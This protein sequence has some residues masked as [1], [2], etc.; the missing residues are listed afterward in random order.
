MQRRVIGGLLIGLAAL[1][2]G[3]ASL[4]SPEVMKAETANFQVPTKLPE[5]GKAMVYVVRPSELGGL[6]RFNVFLDDQEAASE[7]G[8]TRS[9][10]YVYFSVQPGVRKIYSKAENWAEMEFKA[11]AG[12][13]P[14]DG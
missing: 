4:P 13:D 11:D 12:D 10:R 3:C 1:F 14:Q 2:T 7:M 9:S 6:V 5:A 8:Y